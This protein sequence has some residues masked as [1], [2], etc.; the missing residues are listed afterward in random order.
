M[1]IATVEDVPEIKAMALDFLAASDYKELADSDTIENLIIDVV[2]SNPVEK[3]ILLN[4]GVGFLA[5][6]KVPFVFGK[7][8]LA[9]EIA[10]WVN[11]EFRGTGEGLNLLKAFEYWA[12]NVAGC[13]MISMGSLDKSLEK[14]YKKNKYRLYE[15]AYMK[16]F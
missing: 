10:W 2:S 12:R 16:V 13:R 7:A 1:K 14:Y 15:R 5:G 4:P 3:L 8:N 9:T 6:M 11:P